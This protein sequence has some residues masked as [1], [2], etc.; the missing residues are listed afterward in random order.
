[1]QGTQEHIFNVLGKPVDGKGPVVGE[2]DSRM[3]PTVKRRSIHRS[4]IELDTKRAIF[5]TVY[6]D[7]TTS[8]CMLGCWSEVQSYRTQEGDVTTLSPS[9]T[10]S[11]SSPR[12]SS[13]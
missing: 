12:T 7:L 1:M 4:F 9:L 8:T 2:L 5:E 6:D 10:D 11:Y 13:T 3:L